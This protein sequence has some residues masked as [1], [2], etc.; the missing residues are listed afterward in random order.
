ML[1]QQCGDPATHIGDRVLGVRRRHGLRDDGDHH[2]HDVVV[3]SLDETGLRLEMV[4]HQAE[5]NA[6]VGRDRTKRRPRGA[7]RSEAF[8]RRLADPL[9]FPEFLAAKPLAVGHHRH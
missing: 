6:G 5:G 4:L 8:Q 2:A 9:E 1:Q 7:L 3:D